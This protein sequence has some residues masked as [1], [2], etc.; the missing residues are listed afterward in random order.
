[1]ILSFAI[2]EPTRSLM[3]FDKFAVNSATFILSDKK[4]ENNSP[5]QQSLIG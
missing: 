5:P 3:A 4:G 2:I 1:M